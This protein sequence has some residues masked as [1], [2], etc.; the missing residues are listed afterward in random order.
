[1]WVILYLLSISAVAYA[2][3]SMSVT[4]HMQSLPPLTFFFVVVHS[5]LLAR[6]PQSTLAVDVRCSYANYA[7][8]LGDF[9]AP[10][11]KIQIGN[12]TPTICV[13][14][15]ST[16]GYALAGLEH[17]DTCICGNT[18]IDDIQ[19]IRAGSWNC[20]YPCNGDYS[21][22]CGGYLYRTIYRTSLYQLVDFF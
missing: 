20:Q 13:A 6:V 12:N 14:E 11:E 7:G 15:C 10:M 17:G 21:Q 9:A 22:L 2:V 16:R 8:D 3:P 4:F 19:P 18:Y 5:T 1:M